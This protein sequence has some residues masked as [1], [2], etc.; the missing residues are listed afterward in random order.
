[1]TITT[2]GYGDITPATVGGRIIAAMLM[3]I[4]IGLFSFVTANIASRFVVQDEQDGSGMPNRQLVAE[5][6]SLRED[7]RMLRAS[8]HVSD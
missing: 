7:V 8:L 5:I 6:Q 2:V 1:M 3:V 4:G